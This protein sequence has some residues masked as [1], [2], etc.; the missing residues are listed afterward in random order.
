MRREL[1][2]N[3]MDLPCRY[4]LRTRATGVAVRAFSP[5]QV[6][7]TNLQWNGARLARVDNYK[8]KKKS[9]KSSDAIS[10]DFCVF[11]A[12]ERVDSNR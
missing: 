11:S 12:F 10:S 3:F 6:L 9:S 1:T 5:S 4:R 2:I 7:E 8:V